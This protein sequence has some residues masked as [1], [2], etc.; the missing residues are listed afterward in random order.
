MNPGKI[1]AARKMDDASLFRYPPGYRDAAVQTALDWSAWNVQNDPVA[2]TLSPPGTGGDPAHGFAKAVEMCNNNGHCRKFDAGTMCPSYRVTRDEQHL[3]RGRA[4]TLRLAL[5]GQLGAAALA[6]SAVRDALDLCVSCKGC[7]RECPTGV[8][9][10]KMKI[11]F[12]HHWH[13]RHGLST[14][15]SP[16]RVS[17]ALGA[18]GARGCHGLLNLRNT[19]PGAAALSRKVARLLRASVAAALAQRYVPTAACTIAAC[20]R[21]RRCRTTAT[22]CCS[23]TR[24]PT[25]SSPRTRTPRSRCCARPATACIRAAGRRQPRGRCAAGARS[26]QRAWS[27]RRRPKRARMRRRAAALRRAR[28]SGRR[29]RALVPAVAARRI[30]GRWGSART[31]SVLRRAA[32]LIEE[33]LAREHRAGRL[34]LPLSALPRK[35]RAAARSLPS[36]GVRRAAPAVETCCDC[37]RARGRR[38]RVELLRHGG[39]FGYEAAHYDVSMRMAELS[40]LPAVRSADADTLIVADGTSCRHQIADGTRASGA[41]HATHV[42]RVLARALTPIADRAATDG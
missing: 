10:A 13:R 4:N 27:T 36:E 18:V 19:L 21:L 34:H 9:M 31:R 11:E 16:D 1:V 42:V 39:R 35:A 38:R 28:R 26:S 14:Q 24:S 41:R 7:R 3:T 29:P 20:R 8:D 40:L 32:L 2:D 23:S 5:S 17:A 15:G 12:L 22:S 37:P 25:T 30:P 33:F 6:S